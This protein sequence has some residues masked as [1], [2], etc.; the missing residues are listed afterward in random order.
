[1]AETSYTERGINDDIYSHCFGCFINM[2]IHR[3]VQVVIMKQEVKD[4]FESLHLHKKY[5][6]EAGLIVGGIPYWRL[7]DH[8]AS[9][10]TSEEYPYYARQFHGDK[11]DPAGFARAWLHHIHFNDHHWDNWLF[12]D[13]YS[14]PGSGIEANGTLPMP[15]ICIR[16][17]VA[18]WMGAEMA[19][20]H[21]WDMSKWLNGNIDFSDL[22][23]SKIKIHTETADIL[24][25]ILHDIG[26][27]TEVDIGKPKNRETLALMDW[28]MYPPLVKPVNSNG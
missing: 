2:D 16:E 18:D 4:F 1:M 7:F 20:N 9:K 8:D 24:R 6:M 13:G 28:S 22:A 25:G 27:R 12:A 15:E 14:P 26:Y 11:G 10:F 5:V 21:S 3:I 17:M 23:N 19:Y